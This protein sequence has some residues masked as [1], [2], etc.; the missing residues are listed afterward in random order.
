MPTKGPS[1][2]GGG[3]NSKTVARSYK[4]VVASPRLGPA[5]TGNTRP[6]QGKQ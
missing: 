2:P 6:N 1:Q 4:T 5:G 3:K